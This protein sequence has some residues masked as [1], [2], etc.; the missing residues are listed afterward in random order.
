M[1]VQ[2]NRAGLNANQLFEMNDSQETFSTACENVNLDAVI[3][4]KTCPY[5]IQRVL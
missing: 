3:I 2:Q 4:T 5:N 1:H